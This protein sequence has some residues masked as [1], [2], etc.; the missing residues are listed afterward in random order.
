MRMAPALVACDAVADLCDSSEFFHIQMQQLPRRAALVALHRSGQIESRQSAQARLSADPC[1][2]RPREFK[3]RADRA[4]G[5]SLAAQRNH[6]KLQFLNRRC[7]AE[8]W[9][10]GAIRKAR[11]PFALVALEP[12]IDRFNRNAKLQRHLQSGTTFEHS[13]H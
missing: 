9:P 12:L 6:C 13:I 8:A 5:K 1:N 10:T 2:R 4:E 7:R 11:R 3:L